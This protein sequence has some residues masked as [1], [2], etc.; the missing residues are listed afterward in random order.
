[1]LTTPANTLGPLMEADSHD[2]V[3]R[4]SSMNDNSSVASDD[5]SDSTDKNASSK[6]LPEE[7]RKKLQQKVPL[8]G[9]HGKEGGKKGEAGRTFGEIYTNES[10]FFPLAN[11]ILQT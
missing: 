10:Y 4:T 3:Q 8:K 9:S 1:M 11:I 5:S 2:G 6:C 7:R